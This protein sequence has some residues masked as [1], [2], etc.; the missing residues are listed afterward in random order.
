MIR[1]QKILWILQPSHSGLGPPIE[2]MPASS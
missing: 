2:L 1:Q